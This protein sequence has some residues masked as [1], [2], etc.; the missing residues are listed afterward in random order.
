MNFFLLCCVMGFVGFGVID[1]DDDDGGRRRLSFPPPTAYKP[2]CRE[3]S[4]LSRN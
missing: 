2:R 3:K 1:D 4:A